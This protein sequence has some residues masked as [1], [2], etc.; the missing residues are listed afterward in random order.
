MLLKIRAIRSLDRLVLLY[1]ITR[2]L[3]AL[4]S[5]AGTKREGKWISNKGIRIDVIVAKLT[6]E[7]LKEKQEMLTKLRL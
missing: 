1:L 6:Q 3:I 7:L 2:D 4:H 5:S